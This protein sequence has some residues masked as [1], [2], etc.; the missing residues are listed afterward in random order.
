MNQYKS[1]A[2][3]K[4][5][6]KEKLCG[7]YGITMSALLLVGCIS[8][9]ATTVITG[10]FATYTLTQYIIYAAI[11]AAISVFTGIFET[12]TCLLYLN[13]ACGQPY[14]LE[15]V[16]HAVSNQPGNT[17][18]VSF[19]NA[20][21]N[22]I[23]LIPYQIFMH[24]FLISENVTY[25]ML[26]FLSAGIGL[27]I[28]VPISLAISQSYYLLL[29]FPEYTGV[30]A[31]KTSC[32]LMKGNMGRLFYIQASFLPL[33]FLGVLSFGLGLIWLIPYMKM[34]YTLFFLDIMNPSKTEIH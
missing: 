4:D 9:L 25:M 3:L 30:Q 24:L 16:F 19:A 6:A 11:T 1:S 21:T 33:I 34:T 14:R 27:L 17:L 26:M 22:F 10:N 18:T 31:L 20:F 29:D 12:G 32:Q 2:E 5:L 28:Y 23:C 8:F 7:R 13:I 15:D